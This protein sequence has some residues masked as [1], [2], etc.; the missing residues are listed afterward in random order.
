MNVYFLL[1]FTGYTE[2]VSNHAESLRLEHIWT[3]YT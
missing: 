1:N 3:T 2:N